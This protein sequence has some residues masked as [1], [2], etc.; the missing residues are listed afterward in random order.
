MGFS[1]RELQLRRNCELYS[2]LLQ[3]QN[4]EVPEYIEECI[5][6]DDFDLLVDCVKE[7][8][9]EIQSLDDESFTKILENEN[10]VEAKNLLKWWEMY[11]LYIPV[12]A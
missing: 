2:Y 8:A 1:N 9:Q 6:T 4:K 11:Q 3:A 5:V 7:L 12:N 10:S